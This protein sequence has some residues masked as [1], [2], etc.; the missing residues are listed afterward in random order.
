[1]S[2]LTASAH[3]S[4]PSDFPVP[5][6]FPTDIPTPDLTPTPASSPGGDLTFFLLGLKSGIRKVKEL[7][8]EEV[9]EDAGVVGG[10]A[11]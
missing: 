11:A 10:V 4:A 2:P 1:M 8:G 5:A 9:E 3:A 6:S 7:V